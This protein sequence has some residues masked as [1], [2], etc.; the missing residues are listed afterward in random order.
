MLPG[1]RRVCVWWWWG[2][3]GAGGGSLHLESPRSEMLGETVF[4]P[5]QNIYQLLLAAAVRGY[6]N[7]VTWD[8]F[9]LP[10]SSEFWLQGLWDKTS[11]IARRARGHK[12]LWQ[13]CV[14]S[15][16]I[17]RSR[18]VSHS[19]LKLSYSSVAVYYQDPGGESSRTG[20]L[21]Q[22]WGPDEGGCN[23]CKRGN[24]R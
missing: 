13:V 12:N 9:P 8:R 24:T 17:P 20:N 11:N 7:G 14:H 3:G 6:E 2:V 10:H 19:L 21:G 18:S 16:D 15:G 23:G 4:P 22:R 1:S 5:P